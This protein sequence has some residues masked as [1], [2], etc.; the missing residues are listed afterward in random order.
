[1]DPKTAKKIAELNDQLENAHMQAAQDACQSG[2]PHEVWAQVQD[3]HA[4]R[5]RAQR[6]RRRYLGV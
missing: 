2:Q 4:A 1:M 6:I 3:A 5:A